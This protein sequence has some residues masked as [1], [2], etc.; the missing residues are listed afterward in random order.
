MLKTIDE[1][2]T[3][4]E[5]IKAE[6]RTNNSTL[7]FFAL[8]YCEVTKSVKQGI[9]DE[10]FEDNSRMERLDILFA[11]RYIDAYRLFQKSENVSTS[12]L[13]AFQSSQEPLLILQH[14]FLGINAHINLDLG[15]AAAETMS[16]KNVEDINNDFNSINAVLGEMID[17]FQE[18]LNTASPFFK[19]IDKLAASKE[20][21]LMGFSINVAREGAWKFTKEY[22]SATDKKALLALR[23]AKVAKIGELVKFTKSKLITF[24]VKIVHLLEKKDVNTIMDILEG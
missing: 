3:E 16:G 21:M 7:G 11:N 22:H 23:D 8:L 18:R 12:W 10:K 20:E 24:V 6:C 15:I 9:T 4:L 1:V 2:I 14:I 13:V 17:S 5:K 19:W